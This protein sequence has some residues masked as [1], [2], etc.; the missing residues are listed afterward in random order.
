MKRWHNTFALV[1]L[2][3]L[4]ALMY[5]FA[6]SHIV[7]AILIIAVSGVKFALVAF[8]FMEVRKAHPIY[9]I[10]LLVLFAGFALGGLILI[11]E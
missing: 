10:W 3:S 8:Q 4:V 1:A 5:V 6:E 9:G 11:Q 2:L 7:S